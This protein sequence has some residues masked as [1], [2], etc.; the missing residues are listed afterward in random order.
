MEM[1]LSQNKATK[2]LLRS[3]QETLPLFNTIPANNSQLVE[4][5]L[6]STFSP[7]E[8][9]SFRTHKAKTKTLISYI[10]GQCTWLSFHMVSKTSL[11][12]NHYSFDILGCQTEDIL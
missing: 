2:I 1:N 5:Y 6:K 10:Y 9:V 11:H 8:V 7:E 3:T 4:W 12:L